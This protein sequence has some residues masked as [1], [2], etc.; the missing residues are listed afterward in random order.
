[1]SLE[2][3]G[4]LP[5]A[6]DVFPL[7]ICRCLPFIHRLHNTSEVV[8][9]GELRRIVK[10]K[11]LEFKDVKDPRVGLLSLPQSWLMLHDDIAVLFRSLI[12]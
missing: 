7:Q 1:M 3:R 10:D 8:T 11:F 2:R 4:S 5:H 6:C 12:S 9:L